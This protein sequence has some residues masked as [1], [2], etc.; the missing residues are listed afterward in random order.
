MPVLLDSMGLDGVLY[1]SAVVS[2][3]GFLCSY[4]FLPETMGKAL[5]TPSHTHDIADDD[6]TAQP[7]NGVELT[8]A[9]L[10]P[11]DPV[12]SAQ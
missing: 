9:A 10:A 6:L 12:A 4:A 2:A 5:D 8:V 7:P 3:A 1:V 11:V